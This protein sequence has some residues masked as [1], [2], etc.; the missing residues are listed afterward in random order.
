[1]NAVKMEG[2]SEH[3]AE[4]VKHVVDGGGKIHLSS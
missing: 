1:M 2:G 3:R 4:T